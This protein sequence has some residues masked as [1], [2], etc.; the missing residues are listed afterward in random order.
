MKNQDVSKS[1]PRKGSKKAI[2]LL[3]ALFLLGVIV[4]I[5][6]TV[7]VMIH[8]LQNNLSHPELAEGPANRVLNRIGADLDKHL[9]LTPE[10]STAVREELE[11]SRNELRV[12]RINLS[13]DLR[14]V[15]AA[16]VERISDRLPEAKRTLLRERAS[17]RLKPWGLQ[18]QP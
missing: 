12:I 3:V 17:E 9:D 10:E 11:M 16:A 14:T 4:G 2:V 15:A 1:E 6:G 13:Q 8:R 7:S 5:G 18:P